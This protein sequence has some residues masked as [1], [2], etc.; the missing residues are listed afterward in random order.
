MVQ[1][2]RWWT[3]RDTPRGVARAYRALAGLYALV[4]VCA[5]AAGRWL[6][7]TMFAVLAIVHLAV[8]EYHL[9]RG[10]PPRDSG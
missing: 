4:V 9:R 1:W 5:F 6:D 3:Y 10:S 8:A 7:A 2:R